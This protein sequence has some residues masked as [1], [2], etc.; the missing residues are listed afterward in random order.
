MARI[1]YS[2]AVPRLP[3]LPTAPTHQT[4]SLPAPSA[5]GFGEKAGRRQG[6]SQSPLLAMT[7]HNLVWPAGGKG[8]SITLL[9][10]LTWSPP[11]EGLTGE[12]RSEVLGHPVTLA[13]G[14][15]ANTGYGTG[16]IQVPTLLLTSCKLGHIT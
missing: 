12:G 9:R 4:C 10:F 3:Q 16:E 14:P 5:L 6:G 11:A 7:G 15:T 13:A 2:D 8:D 1:S